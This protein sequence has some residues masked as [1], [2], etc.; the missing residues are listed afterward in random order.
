M[1]FHQ[2]WVRLTVMTLFTIFAGSLTNKTKKSIYCVM[3]S[4]FQGELKILLRYLKRKSKTNWKIPGEPLGFRVSQHHKWNIWQ[5][6]R[7]HFNIS[8]WVDGVRRVEL[9]NPNQLFHSCYHQD[10]LFC[11]P[12]LLF[13]VHQNRQ[14]ERKE[15]NEEKKNLCVRSQVI[16]IKG[17]R[18][19]FPSPCF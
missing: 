10:Y 9:S 13:C 3:V 12:G 16:V 7:P 14:Q 18:F 5:D 1:L 11:V 8:S 17:F 6:L 19:L 4:K 15:K 2:K